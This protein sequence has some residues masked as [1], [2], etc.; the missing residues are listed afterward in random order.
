[1]TQWSKELGLGKTMMT[2]LGDPRRDLT[3]ALGVVMDHPDTKHVL[4]N[5]RCKRFSM[6]VDDGVIRAINI[7]AGKDD[8]AGDKNPYVS[9]AEK[10]V[11]DL[12][13]L[14]P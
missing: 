5:R 8:P 12:N 9:F 14:Y 1:M 2:C 7:A 13:T 3:E 4:G 11:E 6:L 10:M